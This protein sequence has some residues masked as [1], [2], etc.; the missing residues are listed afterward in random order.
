MPKLKLHPSAIDGIIYV[1]NHTNTK[2][3]AE[4]AQELNVTRQAL[5]NYMN[6]YGIERICEYRQ[7]RSIDAKS[8]SS[9]K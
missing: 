6:T 8:A 7:M 2:S 1:L 5:R 3:V 9:S 4:A